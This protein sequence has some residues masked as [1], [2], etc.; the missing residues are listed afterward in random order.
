[1]ISISFV[2]YFLTS[3]R[4]NDILETKNTKIVSKR[5]YGRKK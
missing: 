5:K 3:G 2:K 1:V 4:L